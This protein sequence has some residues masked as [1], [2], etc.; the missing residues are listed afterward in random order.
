MTPDIG[1]R[2]PSNGH[3]ALRRPV[4]SRCSSDAS[5][6]GQGE[7]VEASVAY[8]KVPISELGKPNPKAFKTLNR[9]HSKVILRLA[10]A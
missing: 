9:H 3:L 2:P 1:V 7:V 10:S 4:L 5:M 8:E 6:S